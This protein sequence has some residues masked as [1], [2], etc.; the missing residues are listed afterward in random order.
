MSGPRKALQGLTASLPE[1][2]Q[3][4][5]T[6]SATVV[7]RPGTGSGSA[8]AAAA[9]ANNKMTLSIASGSDDLLTRWFRQQVR[10]KGGGSVQKAFGIGAALFL[11]VA[12][13][14]NADG[15]SILEEGV[16]P[17]EVVRA[18]AEDESDASEN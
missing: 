13:Y 15:K 12:N 10:I 9:A 6:L 4:M 5:A 14:Y 3:T 1:L 16:L 11:T 8:A 17:S 7:A 18:T 2:R